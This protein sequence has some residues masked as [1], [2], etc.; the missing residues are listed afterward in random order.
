MS[1]RKKR[2]HDDFAHEIDAHLAIEID[3]LMAEGRTPED[4]RAE[5]RRA[6]GNVTAARERFYESSRLLWLDQA[7]Q[8]VRYALR[9]FT[10]TPGFTL[11]AVLTLALGIGATTAV[12]SVVN[13]LLLRPLPYP[14]ADRLVRI[15]EHVPAAESPSGTPVTTTG[16]NQDAFLWW[17]DETKTM[18]LAASMDAAATV[19][20]GETTLRLNGARVSAS[21]FAMLG[22]RPALGRLLR[23]GDERETHVVVLADALWRRVFASDRGVVGKSITLDGQPHTIVGV[24]PPAVGF[25]QPQ[26]EFWTP[27]V[28]EP[29]TAERIMTVNVLAR[30]RD[31]ASIAAASAEANIIGSAFIGDA[32]R[33]GTQ[34]PR[35]EVVGLQDHIIGEFRPALRALVTSVALVLLIVCMNVANL[36]LA[37]GGARQHELRIRHAIGAARTRIVRQVL[38]E[39]AVLA[40]TGSLAGLAVAHGG[41]SLARRL[42]TI[43]LP[44]LYGGHRDLLPGLERV[45]IDASVLAFASA[46]C[47]VTG[48]VFGVLPALQYSRT[49]SVLRPNARSRSRR[50]T[51]IRR[52][53]PAALTI[54]QLSL[55]TILLVAAGL[56]IG[57]FVRLSRVDL[58]FA[59]ARTL[60]FELVVPNGL[61]AARR[62]ALAT[63][64]SARVSKLPGVQAAG[65][66]GAAP[67]STLQ[68]GWIL[69]PPGMS[70]KDVFGQERLR[71]QRASV[72]SP[73]YLRAIGATLVEGRWLD[74]ADARLRPPPMLVNRELARRFFGSVRPIGKTVDLGGISWQVVGVVADVRA[75]ALDLEPDP[76]AYVDPARMNDAARAAGWTG[77]GFVDATPTFLSFAMRATGDPA[78]LVPAIRVLV[79][80]LE[81]LAAVDGAVNMQDVVAGSLT[82]PRFYA[83]ALGLFALMAAVLAALGVYSLLA[84]AVSLR[85]PEIGLRMA[86]GAQ[87]REVMAM[88]LREG[89]ALTAL[90]LAIGVAGAIVLTRYLRG[91]LFGVAPL[92]AVTFVG[93]TAAFAVVAMLA[94]YVPARRATRTDPLAALRTE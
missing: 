73:G 90:G 87:R 51:W 17:R 38:T 10:R 77:F 12:F 68:L 37:R 86:L 52:G 34:S 2:S 30:L 56:L 92:D 53:A 84:Y 39:S 75:Q 1:T 85:T 72:T 65:F 24:T 40:I 93:T 79:H 62:L 50:L 18:D 70:P 33:S 49:A 15:V 21:L 20:I 59:P 23:S 74:D 83:I 89:G 5:A 44:A 46:V 67:L 88:V 48:L 66:T 4:A 58:G 8:D 14:R 61:T 41:L 55:A 69:T 27:Y 36:L 78:G 57:S 42:E 47:L 80:Q 6:F 91:M 82:R 45:T 3:R 22:V 94:S 16:M 35:F 63:D 9:S 71:L 28:V 19:S 32:P 13:T 43:D 25:P 26:T 54:T 76:W 64:L 7:W 11:A 60:T 31:G 81:P 29:D